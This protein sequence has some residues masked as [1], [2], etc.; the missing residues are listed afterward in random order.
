MLS[1]AQIKQF[2]EQLEWYI[3]RNEFGES[4]R[5]LK[6]ILLPTFPNWGLINV[7]KLNSYNIGDI[8]SLR[9]LDKKYHCHRI[10]KI[11]SEFVTTKGDNLE[12]QDYET[13]VPIKNIEGI[14]KLILPRQKRNDN[15][16]L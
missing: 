15:A 12:Q 13:K 6:N 3:H 1:E 5:I 11:N 2:I 10:I 7:K 9:T 8:I 14:V 16:I 4:L